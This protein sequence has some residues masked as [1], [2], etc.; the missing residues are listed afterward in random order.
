MFRA[1]LALLA[2]AFTTSAARAQTGLNTLFATGP[3]GGEPVSLAFSYHLLPT[4]PAMLAL[5]Q[6]TVISS[7]PAA[8]A[9]TYLNSGGALALGGISPATPFLLNLTGGG[10]A[11]GGGTFP[12]GFPALPLS[13]PAGTPIGPVA[14]LA[15]TLTTPEDGHA[16]TLAYLVTDPD[17][18]TVGGATLRVPD[19]GWWVLGFS[20]LGDSSPDPKTDPVPVTPSIPGTNDPLPQVPEPATLLLA[21]VGLAGAMGLRRRKR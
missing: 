20:S 7:N 10:A 6:F 9:A 3:N 15:I 4:N 13:D 2:L 19:G 8:V 16:G 14:T 5:T 17:G 21:G 18:H 1:V 12:V 11:L